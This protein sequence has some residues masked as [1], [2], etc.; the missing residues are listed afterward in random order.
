[1]FGTATARTAA[2]RD[3]NQY[4]TGQGQVMQPVEE[5]AGFA[6]FTLVFSCAQSS[7]P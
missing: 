6:N 5:Q 1:L 4:C 3:A 2:I 7:T